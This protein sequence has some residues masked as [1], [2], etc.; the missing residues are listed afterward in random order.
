MISTKIIND[1]LFK[2]SNLDPSILNDIFEYVNTN[3]E[4]F[5]DPT[6]FCIIMRLI[7]Y[8]QNGYSLNP[9]LAETRKLSLYLCISIYITNGDYDLAG[10]L[11]RFSGIEVPTQPESSHIIDNDTIPSI[12]NHDVK[13]FLKMFKTIENDGIISK[14]IA[15]EVIYKK[16]KL[17]LNLS[18]DICLKIWDLSSINKSENLDEIE[19]IISMHLIDCLSSGLLEFLPDELTPEFYNE[20]AD[21]VRITEETDLDDSDDDDDHSDNESISD[22]RTDHSY[23]THSQSQAVDEDEDGDEYEESDTDTDTDTD[24]EIVTEIEVGTNDTEN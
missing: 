10:P 5:I 11:A 14:E 17:K 2:V 19:F 8:S 7:G 22:S 20:L 16:A 13:R 6:G 24:T 1:Q 23:T 3:D 18:N 9:A 12:T 15:D 21:K 4:G